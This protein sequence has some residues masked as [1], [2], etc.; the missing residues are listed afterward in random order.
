MR[1]VLMIAA[2]A[3]LF[4]SPAFAFHC[5]K[6]MTAIDEALPTTTISAEDKAK[7]VE[8]RARGETEHAAGDHA[9]SVKTLGEAKTLLGIK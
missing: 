9:A 8:L 2:A 7:V 4:A 1:K 6:D 3:A 5:P